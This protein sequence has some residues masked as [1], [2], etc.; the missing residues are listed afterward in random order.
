MTFLDVRVVNDYMED[1]LP[2]EVGEFIMRGESVMKEYYKKPQETAQTFRDGWLLTGD[3]ATID[4]EGYITLVDRKKDMIISG[5]ENVY[6]VEVEQTLNGS[7]GIVECAII[8]LPDSKWG[9][10]VTAVIVKKEDIE[11][12]EEDI[13]A[14]CRGYLAGY[15]LPRQF[16]YVES[17]PRNVSG[18]IL[19][20]Q[21]RENWKEKIVN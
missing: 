17:F 16:I 10:V 12:D 13:K 11:I 5:G 19:K 15:K 4:D 6:S 7:P 1:V 20:F 8:G 9:E 3:L 18:K 21:L 2:G 14:Y